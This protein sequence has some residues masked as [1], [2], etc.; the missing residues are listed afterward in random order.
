MRDWPRDRD[1]SRKCISVVEE[2]VVALIVDEVE[3]GVVVAEAEGLAVDGVEVAVYEEGE[4]EEVNDE[5]VKDSNRLSF[6]QSYVFVC[7]R[8]V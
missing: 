3:A 7:S 2:G 1:R 6:N 4:A 8:G 5:A